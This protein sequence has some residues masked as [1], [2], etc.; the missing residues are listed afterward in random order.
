V[1]DIVGSIRATTDVWS[2]FTPYASLNLAF[3]PDRDFYRVWGRDLRVHV[4]VTVGISYR[5]SL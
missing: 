3:V 2:R 5:W 4:W 1:S